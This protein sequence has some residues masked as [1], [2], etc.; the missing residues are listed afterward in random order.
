M[1]CQSSTAGKGARRGAAAV[2]FALVA[3]FLVTLVLGM[4]ELGRAIMV[5]EMLSNAAQKACRT[6]AQPGKASSDATSEVANIMSDNNVTGYSTTI[7]VN[8]VAADISTAKQ[9]DQISIKVSVPV[10]QVAWTTTFFYLTGATME[11]E[12]V[13]MMRQG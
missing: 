13:V 11:S 1:R 9:F 3:P 4:M 6:A 7:L 8:G 10:S 12:T 5:K 2:E